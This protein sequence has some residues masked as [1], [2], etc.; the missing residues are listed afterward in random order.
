MGGR[1]AL[2]SFPF[3]SGAQPLRGAPAIAVNTDGDFCPA[4]ETM[5]LWMSSDFR[6]E[7]GGGL[8]G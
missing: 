5:L 6:G 2:P 8:G 3:F 1:R 4:A 7:A